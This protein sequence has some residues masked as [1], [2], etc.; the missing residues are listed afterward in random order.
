M[1]FTAD[2]R[3]YK[4]DRNAAGVDKETG[5]HL[6]IFAIMRIAHKMISTPTFERTFR[7]SR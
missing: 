2:K 7:P 3:M 1:R 4:N 5:L 6:F